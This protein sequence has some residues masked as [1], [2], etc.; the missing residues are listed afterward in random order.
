MFGIYTSLFRFA[1]KYKIRGTR[2][3]SVNFI[4]EDGGDP[5]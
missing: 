2:T 3:K 1:G 4:I 5:Q